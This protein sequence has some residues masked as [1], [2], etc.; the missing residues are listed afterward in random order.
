MLLFKKNLCQREAPSLVWASLFSSEHDD[1]T[2][3]L[4]RLLRSLKALSFVK[5]K[6]LHIVVT[7]LIAATCHLLSPLT[8]PSSQEQSP[9]HCG[10]L[11]TYLCK[12]FFIQPPSSYS[13]SNLLLAPLLTAVREPSSPQ[14]LL[15][16][17]SILHTI[18]SISTWELKSQ[19]V[20]LSAHRLTLAIRLWGI[21]D[22]SSSL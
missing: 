12:V 15:V 22:Q 21:L 3:P 20:N 6:S 10:L 14:A 1:D 17:W 7:Q 18:P 16:L 11:S 4:R 2:I 8:C 19:V 13:S 9:P 5:Q